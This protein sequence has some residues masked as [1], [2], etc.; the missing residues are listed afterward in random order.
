M[1]SDFSKG[2]AGWYGDRP[3]I[4][5]SNGRIGCAELTTPSRTRHH[6]RMDLNASSLDSTRWSGTWGECF[7]WSDLPSGPNDPC[8]Q[9]DS[10]DIDLQVDELGDDDS[11]WASRGVATFEDGDRSVEIEFAIEV[12]P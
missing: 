5:L 2:I 4:V 8:F 10:F 3:Y 9:F 11:V 6:V 7:D 12:C 1:G